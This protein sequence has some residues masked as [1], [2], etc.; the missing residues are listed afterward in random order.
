MLNAQVLSFRRVD[1]IIKEKSVAYFNK[2]LSV[3]SAI[4]YHLN[5]IDLDP[6]IDDPI[7]TRAD[8]TC[9]IFG[10]KR[11]WGHA[12]GK[13]CEQCSE[14]RQKNIRLWVQLS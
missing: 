11:I 5:E 9:M 1:P 14:I 8:A 6:D 4:E 3:A 13:G 7:L 12:L 10:G 2:G